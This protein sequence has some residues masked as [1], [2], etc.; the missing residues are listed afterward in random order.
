MSTKLIYN[1]VCYT[2][3]FYLY[4]TLLVDPPLSYRAQKVKSSHA[5]YYIWGNVGNFP[6]G[7]LLRP[8]L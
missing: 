2:S 4:S 8:G 6:Q 3:L 7:A 5:T 1:A